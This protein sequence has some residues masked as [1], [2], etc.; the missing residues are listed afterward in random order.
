MN[1]KNYNENLIKKK[2]SPPK[3]IKNF[4]KTDE[5]DKFLDLYKKLPITVHN[6]KQ[7]VIKKRWLQGY[8]NDLEK[9]FR[10][11]LENEIGPF[12][13]DNLLTENKEEILGLFQES[14]APIGLH[15]DSGFNKDHIFYKQVLLPLTPKGS[16]I[17][18]KNKYYGLSTNFTIDKT[19]LSKKLSYGQNI[20]SNEHVK[21]YGEKSFDEKI[22]KEFLAHE[23]IENL[24]GLDVELIYEWSLGSLLIFDRSHLHASSSQIEDKKIGLAC[25][26]KQ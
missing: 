1:K 19:E 12:K 14:F 13:M 18:F 11:K 4:L 5:I 17:I 20:R 21:I 15:V 9:L 2:E 24:R 10:K 23:K 3:I 16:T 7:N 22:H 6:K 25:F 8:D 26:T